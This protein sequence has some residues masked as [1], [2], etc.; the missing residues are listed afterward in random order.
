MVISQRKTTYINMAAYTALNKAFVREALY[1][2]ISAG[3]SEQLF[4]SQTASRLLQLRVRQG[5]GRGA[6]WAYVWVSE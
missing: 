5:L 6:T 2:A 4:K 3:L 1:K